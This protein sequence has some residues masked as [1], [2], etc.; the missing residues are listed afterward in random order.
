MIIFLTYGEGNDKIM[1]SDHPFSLKDIANALQPNKMEELTGKP[2]II[3]INASRG[4]KLNKS[5]SFNPSGETTGEASTESKISTAV[6][7]NLENY[8]L[9]DKDIGCGYSGFYPL[10]AD[11]LFC[12]STYDSRHNVNHRV[13]MKVIIFRLNFQI[14]CPSAMNTVRGLFKNFAMYLIRIKKVQL[15]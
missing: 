6:A 2:K 13:S 15:K 10:N 8:T 1:A 7:Y 3:M 12:Y 4:N 9:Y 5:V 11:F 14:I